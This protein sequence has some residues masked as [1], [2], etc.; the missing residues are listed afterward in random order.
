MGPNASAVDTLQPL[1]AAASPMS[2]EASMPDREPTEA[3]ES[4]RGSPGQGQLR[5]SFVQGKEGASLLRAMGIYEV[6]HRVGGNAAP[7][8]PT[9][10]AA[11]A[12]AYKPAHDA[13]SGSGLVNAL[14]GA[15]LQKE[16]RRGPAPGM[17]TTPPT[18]PNNM[19]RAGSQPNFPTVTTHNLDNAA[20][21]HNSVS[22]SASALPVQPRKSWTPPKIRLTPG[23][24]PEMQPPSAPIAV[25]ALLPLRAHGQVEKR[26]DE[27]GQERTKAEFLA[28]YGTED[29]WNAAP[30]PI[31][32]C[33]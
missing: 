9:A 6:G 3:Q 7:L 33:A 4:S 21:G 5:R 29:K 8:P 14:G 10:A 13:S 28:K 18:V 1:S 25:D 11:P 31:T 32:L 20:G 2:H 24:A 30:V 27:D 26:I 12:P 16:S 22:A 19:P 23:R 17:S 15:Q